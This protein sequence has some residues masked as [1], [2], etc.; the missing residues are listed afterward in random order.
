MRVDSPERFC[1]RGSQGVRMNRIGIIQGRLSASVDGKIQCFPKETWSEEFTKARAAGLQCLE[2]VFGRDG[3]SVN[4]LATADGITRMRQLSQRT[5]VEVRSVCAD[6]F[7][8][9]PLLRVTETV[10]QQRLQRLQW[11]LTHCAAAGIARI[12][13]PF[14]DRSEIRTDNELALAAASVQA[15]TPTATELGVE[16]HLETS[17]PPERFRELLAQLDPNAVK[18]N[19]DIGNSAALGYDPDAEFAAYGERIGSV[20]V[21]DRVLHGSTVPL[22]QGHADFRT[23][24]AALRSLGYR[25]DFILQVAR[26]RE[27]Q[28]VSWARH[29]RQFVF[30]HWRQA[31]QAATV[32]Q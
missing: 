18:V 31:R 12:V 30:R 32:L 8:D 28:E 9:S 10:R 14:V 29:N 17:L 19:Y 7:M 24:F 26:G 3:A 2:W 15:A 16:L 23:C 11:L 1:R 27:G 6:Y 21:K 5:R 22:G 20:H 4:P 25:G 13:L